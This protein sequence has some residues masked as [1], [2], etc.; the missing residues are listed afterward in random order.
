M[1]QAVLV[2]FF[3]SF[4]TVNPFTWTSNL[5]NRYSCL[6]H[7]IP[8]DVRELY[9]ETP[10]QE[11]KVGDF[12]YNPKLE[13][14][15]LVSLPPITRSQTQ[16]LRDLWKWKDVALGDGRDYFIPRPRA[17]GTLQNN[18]L[19]FHDTNDCL[20]AQDNKIEHRVKVSEC[21]ILSNC[22][23]FDILL[24][25]RLDD[26][27]QDKF[28]SPN[29]EELELKAKIIAANVLLDQLVY[30]DKSKYKN[31]ALTQSLTTAF[32]LPGIVY[33]SSSTKSTTGVSKS[34]KT[35]EYK[36]KVNEIAG[37]LD[38]EGDIQNITK[39]T[40]LVAS[41]IA[42]R[43]SRPERDVP[44]VSFCFNCQRRKSILYFLF[45]IKFLPEKFLYFLHA[46]SKLLQRS[47]LTHPEMLM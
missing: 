11:E 36:D 47:V 41:G 35:E 7:I 40:C 1:F 27:P 2:L 24:V 22:A 34:F 29:K 33:D 26:P 18:F 38:Y 9:A 46:S 19:Q 20:H 30:Y 32:D 43:P 6:K 31:S 21:S 15:H 14:I 42:L 12:I 44:F 8:N 4:R 25:L 28:F 13:S 5:S 17:I 3:T 37:Y 16:S 23:R 10:K 45:D 39:H